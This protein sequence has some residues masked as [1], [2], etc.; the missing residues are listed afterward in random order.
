M[1]LTVLPWWGFAILSAVGLLLLV[2]LIFAIVG[3][4]TSE[5]DI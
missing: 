3:L 1:S 4:S 5:Y 2:L